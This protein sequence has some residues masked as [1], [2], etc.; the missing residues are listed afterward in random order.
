[1]CEERQS[2]SRLLVAEVSNVDYPNIL[3]DKL[4]YTHPHDHS[5][6]TTHH[7]P[8]TLLTSTATAIIHYLY[9]PPRSSSHP[10]TKMHLPTFLLIAL[11]AATTAQ[12]LN[13]DST[14][15]PFKRN[16]CPHKPKEYAVSYLPCDLF[17]HACLPINLAQ[18]K[19]ACTDA[20]HGEPTQV[21]N[22]RCSP[23]SFLLFFFW[24]CVIV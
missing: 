14:T 4:L 8:S 10:I 18:A 12:E 3:E 1:M 5:I 6:L 2:E 15:G 23:L 9:L 20:G 11:T 13:P 7:D 21:R 16:Q 17:T 24:G 22:V 19:K